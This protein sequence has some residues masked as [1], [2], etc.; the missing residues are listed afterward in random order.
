MRLHTV[1]FAAGAAATAAAGDVST[2]Y[3]ATSNKLPQL[4]SSNRMGTLKQLKTSQR[5]A[6][7]AAGLFDEGRYQ[8]LKTA[9]CSGGKV[10][11][12]SCSNVDL[13]ASLPHG[14]MGSGDREG[15]DI[16]GTHPYYPPLLHPI[17]L[18]APPTAADES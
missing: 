7:R 8:A 14:Q 2:D 1:A 9:K 18:S 5:D 10:G 12:Y 16:W 11:E 13:V 6:S 17:P 15:N 3:L 4:T